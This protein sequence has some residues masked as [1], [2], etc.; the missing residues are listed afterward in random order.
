MSENG[1]DKLK[2]LIRQN[3]NHPS[4]CMWGLFNERDEYD[5]NPIEYIKEL[6]VLAHQEAPTRPTTSA[7]NQ[8]GHINYLTELIAWNKYNGWY[9]GTPQDIGVWRDQIHYDRPELQMG[10]CYYGA[11]ASILSTKDSFV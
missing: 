7:S 5:D 2:E 1:K 3:Y 9:G 10:I 8:D 4:I 11:G 6:N